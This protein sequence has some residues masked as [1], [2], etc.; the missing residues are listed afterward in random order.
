MAENTGKKPNFAIMAPDVFYALKNHDAIKDCI[1]YTQ[2]GV[3]TL[4]L[5]AEFEIENIYILGDK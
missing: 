2:K 5:I 1:K 4:D 3:I